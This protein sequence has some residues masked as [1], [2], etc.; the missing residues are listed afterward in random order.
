[1]LTCALVDSGFAQIHGAASVKTSSKAHPQDS[2]ITANLDLCVQ[3]GANSDPCPKDPSLF[4]V[5]VAN[6]TY[7]YG[8]TLN[9]VVAAQPYQTTGTLT[10]TAN[11]LLICTLQAGTRESCPNNST[12]FD[13]GTYTLYGYYNPPDGS[14]AVQSLPVMVTVLKD[15]SSIGLVSSLNP[16][17]DG[18]AITFTATV[19]GG[20]GEPAS[21]QVSFTVDGGSTHI[22]PLDGTGAASFTTATLPIGSHQIVASYAGSTN[23]EPAADQSYMQVIIPPGTS[24]TLTSSVNPSALNQN[25]TFTSNVSTSIAGLQPLGAVSFN[26]GTKTFATVLVSAQGIASAPPISTLASGTHNI[27]AN[28]SGDAAT[29]SSVSP[30]LV[31]QVTYPLTQAGYGFTVT[32]T[33][34]PVVLGTGLTANLTVTVAAKNGF[35]EPVTLTCGDL[36][37]ESTCTFGETTI[38]AGGG[39]TTLD[40]HVTSPH[41]CGSSAPYFYGMN[42][43]GPGVFRY[44]GPA[45]AGLLLVFLP[46]RRRWHKGLLAL[47][48]CLSLAGLGGC[49]STCT[50]FGTYPGSYTFQVI[51][52]APASTS[53]ASAGSGTPLVVPTSVAL[54]VKI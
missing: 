19:V 11:N 22:S 35:S 14:A 41:D 3:G 31:Q 42:R 30:V 39:S 9:G 45:L 47:F 32:V 25:V 51:G 33:P 50:D 53:G 17:P 10:I 27:T 12:D 44:G 5:Y 21:G 4:D 52:T 7:T 48:A 46:R 49:S 23:F 1:L 15:V 40:L 29:G 28:Y 54:T 8:E 20:Y 34:S 16:A 24:T 2:D 18:S 6:I 37:H 43:P 38:P 26:D 13:P 36:P